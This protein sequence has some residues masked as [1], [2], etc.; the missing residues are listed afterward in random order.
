MSIWLADKLRRSIDALQTYGAAGVSSDVIAFWE[1]GRRKLIRKS[2]PQRRMDFLFESAGQGCTYLV[3]AHCAS[4]F[5]RFLAASDD[6][7]QGVDFHDWLLYAWTRSQ[8]YR[9]HIDAVPTM[10]YRQH[11]ENVLGVNSGARGAQWPPAARAFGWYR[12]QVLRIADLIRNGP[13]FTTECAHVIAALQQR[14]L[15]SRLSRCPAGWAVAAPI[16][17]PSVVLRRMRC[18]RDL[19]GLAQSGALGISNFAISPVQPV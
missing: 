12:A 1:D 13:Q 18:G 15:A 16:Q 5:R 7:V 6:A 14:S 17:R 3:T 10:L 8:G 9:W 2:Y 4:E 19:A 11:G